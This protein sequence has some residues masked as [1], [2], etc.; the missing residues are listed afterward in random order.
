MLGRESERDLCGGAL[1]LTAL[2]L[3]ALGLTVMGLTKVDRHARDFSQEQIPRV[4]ANLTF[5]EAGA[6]RKVLEEIFEQRAYLQSGEMNA[7]AVAGAEA[8]GKAP[9]QF[10]VDVEDFGFLEDSRVPAGAHDRKEYEGLFGNRLSFELDVFGRSAY[11]VFRGPFVTEAFHDGVLHL[12]TIV[13][14]DIGRLRMGEE[15]LHCECCRESRR[16][17]TRR[18]EDH[19]GSDEI[20][21]ID[22]ASLVREFDDLRDEVFLWFGSPSLDGAA[23]NVEHCY[24]SCFGFITVPIARDRIEAAEIVRC[25]SEE[26]LSIASRLVDSEQPRDHS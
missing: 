16:V 5:V 21:R 24:G 10:A 18:Y 12:R 19:E 6:L 26:H 15:S 4:P 7:E 3:T 9:T 8:K 2:G 14:E 1:C 13:A 23:E 11:Q 22:I 25:A 17:G 20:L